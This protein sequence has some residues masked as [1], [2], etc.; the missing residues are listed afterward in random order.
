MSPITIILAAAGFVCLIASIVLK[1]MDK[2]DW[3]LFGI[4]AFMAFL[5][6]FASTS[7]L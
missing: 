5:A 4:G 6:C 7:P 1:A 3:E 2:S